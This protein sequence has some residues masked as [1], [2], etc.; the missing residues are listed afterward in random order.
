[1]ELTLIIHANNKNLNDIEGSEIIKRA[2]DIYLKE[3]KKKKLNIQK[4]NF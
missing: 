3:T 2:L 1:M 4:L